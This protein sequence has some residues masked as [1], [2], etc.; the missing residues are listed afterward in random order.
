[1]LRKTWNCLHSAQW[2]RIFCS[3]KSS[4]VGAFV[5]CSARPRFNYTCLSS[6][7]FSSTIN[8]NCGVFVDISFPINSK[9]V[10]SGVNPA[11]SFNI[12]QSTNYNLEIFKEFVR[13]FLHWLS[14]KLDINSRATSH[15]KL[16]C[17][18]SFVET[19]IFLPIKKSLFDNL[20]K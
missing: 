9:S 19:N 8:H 17:N 5:A 15:N 3:L 1:M 14:M 2:K 18:L 13:E 10:N 4:S 6:K 11:T 7:S 20:P 12:I 16:C